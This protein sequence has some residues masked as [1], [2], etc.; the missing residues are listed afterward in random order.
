MTDDRAAAVLSKVVLH[1]GVFVAQV[2]VCFVDANGAPTFILNSFQ[3]F[4][5]LVGEVR[6]RVE[7]DDPFPVAEVVFEDFPVRMVAE[8][9]VFGF[10]RRV[11]TDLFKEVERARVQFVQC[12]KTGGYLA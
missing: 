4:W 2:I 11:G 5:K 12:F 1:G 6:N 7:G 10:V 8:R 3:K 9:D